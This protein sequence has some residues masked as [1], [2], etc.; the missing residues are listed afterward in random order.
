MICT[1]GS[2]FKVLIAVRTQ[3]LYVIKT[4]RCLTEL[5]FIKGLKYLPCCSDRQLQAG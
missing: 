4:S 1:E 3:N 2:R 5:I